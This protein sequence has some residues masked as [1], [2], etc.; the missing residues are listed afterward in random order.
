MKI[1]QLKGRLKVYQSFRRPSIW[2]NMQISKIIKWLPVVLSVLG[3]LGY[4]SRDTELIRTGVSVAATLAQGD[5]IGLEKANEWLGEN[6][7]KATSDTKAE[8]KPKPE[9]KQKSIATILHIQ[10][11]I[12]KSMMAI[13]CTLSIATAGNTKSAWPIS[14]RQKSTRLMVRNHET[15]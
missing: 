9:Q 15:I 12:I 7:V 2:Q 6:V 10:R 3:A 13:P 1:N 5:N 11:K 4:S 14:M 8:A